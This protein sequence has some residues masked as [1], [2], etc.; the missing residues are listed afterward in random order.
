MSFFPSYFGSTDQTATWGT[1]FYM[2]GIGFQFVRIGGID[3]AFKEAR[4][5]FDR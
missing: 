1:W 3:G 2:N 5:A 4:T